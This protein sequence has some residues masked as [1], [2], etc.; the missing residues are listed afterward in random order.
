MPKMWCKQDDN[1]GMQCKASQIRDLL[2][3]HTFY[4]KK[5]KEKAYI[6]EIDDFI[7]NNAGAISGVEFTEVLE[8]LGLIYD[9]L[10]E[11][12]RGK[13]LDVTNILVLRSD[14]NVK[15]R[16]GL[17]VG[18]DLA[19]FNDYGAVSKTFLKRATKWED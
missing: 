6:K 9:I 4:H 7:Y 19:I 16:N 2:L 13:T 5:P 18:K 11:E 15:L 8:L 3:C 12:K 1:T 17:R 10:P 14:I